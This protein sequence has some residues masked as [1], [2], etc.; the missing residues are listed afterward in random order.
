MKNKG[1]PIDTIRNKIVWNPAPSACTTEIIEKIPITN[2][3]I[4]NDKKF[5]ILY[6]LIFSL[7]LMKIMMVESATTDANPTDNSSVKKGIMQFLIDCEG[8]AKYDWTIPTIVAK[9]SVVKKL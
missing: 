4:K 5:V 8:S 3:N 7:R 2:G 6:V 1:V 9:I